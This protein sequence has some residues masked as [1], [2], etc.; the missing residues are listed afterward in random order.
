[1]P[2]ACS[3]RLKICALCLD[4]VCRYAKSESAAN[5]LSSRQAAAAS[6]AAS[7]QDTLKKIMSLGSG[8]RS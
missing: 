7:A 6:A 8:W 4:L 3:E 1:M 2:S 5:V